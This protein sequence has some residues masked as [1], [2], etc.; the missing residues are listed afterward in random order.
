MT[1]KPDEPTRRTFMPQTGA[2]LGTYQILEP[3]G[4]GGMGEVFLAEDQSLGR[5][6][7]LKF[8]PL[9]LAGDE[10]YRKRFLREARAAAALNHPNIVHIYEVGEHE[11]RPYFAME[12]VEGP[13]LRDRIPV[14]GMGVGASLRIALPLAEALAEAHAHGIVH[15]DLKPANVVLDR[16]GRPKLLDFGLAALSG[17]ERMT[18]V[19]STLGTVGYMAPEQVRGQEPDPRSDLFSLGVILYQMLTGAPAFR[20]DN[21]AATLEAVLKE[22]PEP[23]AER[24]P[25]AS[26]E[27]QRIVSK[28]LA[29]DA[30]DRYGGAAGLVADLSDEL[31]RVEGSAISRASAAAIPVAVSPSPARKLLVPALLVAAA[32]VALFLWRPWG[33]G[34][35]VLEAEAA[36]NRLVVLYFENVAEPE[37]PKRLGE[38]LANLLITDFS[39]AQSMQVVSSQRLYDILKR[40]KHEGEKRIDPAVASQVA[41]ESQAKWMLTGSILQS[42]PTLVLSAELVE[43]RTGD[44]VAS[45]RLAGEAGETVFAVA[46][47]LSG[48]LR[49]DLGLDVGSAGVP[50]RATDARQ[51]AYRLYL[52]G[53]EDQYRY[54]W[55]EARE[56]LR[57]AVEVDSTFAPAWLRLAIMERESPERKRAYAETA[58]RFQEQLNW[59]DRLIVDVQIREADGDTEGALALLRRITERD[60]ED[61]EVWFALALGLRGTQ[62]TADAVNA[63]Q[64][65]VAIDPEFK[66]AHNLLAYCYDEL[67]DGEASRAAI[68]EYIRLA[69]NEPNPL[70]TAGDL[71]AKRGE[72]REAAAAYER[73]LA[74]KPD[75]DV[76]LYKLLTIRTFLEEY[77]AVA[78]RAAELRASEDPDHRYAGAE[79]LIEMLTWQGRWREAADAILAALPGVPAARRMEPTAAAAEL[80]ALAGRRDD[81]LRLAGA[82]LAGRDSGSPWV[83]DIAARAY[84][85]CGAADRAAAL[86]DSVAL[87]VPGDNPDAETTRWAVRGHA[88]MAKGD[89]AQAVYAYERMHQ[90]QPD[91]YSL[92]LLGHAYLG[93]GQPELAVTLLEKAARTYFG[94]RS[95]PPEG[96]RVHFDLGRA[97]EAVGEPAKAVEQYKTFLHI[98]RNGDP[99]LPGVDEARRRLARL[100]AG[101]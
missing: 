5:K 66:N 23:L 47:K 75:F 90:V 49:R 24:R 50:A 17:G 26:P 87:L 27:L 97:Y 42:E 37:D 9:H 80:C 3:I 98:W 82:A 4:S 16:S 96:V 28:L 78:A 86:A 56:K 72:L 35:P 43:I 45:K 13:A 30:V 61:K 15:R 58:K 101:S 10:A 34:R 81:A 33:A 19:G 83:V 25:E 11:G 68:E 2:R 74:L 84:L 32:L 7:A 95:V 36:A 31:R 52:E 48:S 93:A 100:E 77:D 60:P 62:R 64:R 12:H 6:V 89:T 54:F 38:I 41:K 70:D 85:F 91:F 99:G 94:G 20:R 67:G 44:V 63:L 55:P 22:H 40:L 76:S 46:E 8:L 29:K 69:P 57:R 92:A 79:A 1:Q 65:V 71:H 53:V 39:N 51:E 14:E 18:Q 21:E 88:A 59:R 73:A